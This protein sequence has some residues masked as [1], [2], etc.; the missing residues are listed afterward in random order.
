M[1]VSNDLKDGI[2]HVGPYEFDFIRLA[3]GLHNTFLI[4]TRED[5][6][7]HAMNHIQF[8]F[9]GMAH[10]GNQRACILVYPDRPGVVP[11]H[12]GNPLVA[13]YRAIGAQG[14]NRIGS[15]IGLCR[16]DKLPYFLSDIS[17]ARLV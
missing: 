4:I 5:P 16:I 7:Y 10:N 12:P 14:P 11:A 17:E 6:A 9:I 3:T 13:S 15:H 8:Q 2:T 1:E